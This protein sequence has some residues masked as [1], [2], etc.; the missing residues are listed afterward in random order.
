MAERHLEATGMRVAWIKFSTASL[1]NAEELMP[2]L[3]H[4]LE[5]VP[6]EPGPRTMLMVVQGATQEIE[7]LTD[8]IRAEQPGQNGHE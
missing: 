2:L 3:R 5:R 7:A 4:D 8:A 1:A 6:G